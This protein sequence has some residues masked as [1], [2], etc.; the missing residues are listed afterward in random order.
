WDVRLRSTST[1]GNGLPS[2]AA[3][4]GSASTELVHLVFTRAADGEAQFYVDGK[5]QAA[6]RVAGDFSNWDDKQRLILANEHTG[7]R[8]WSGEFHRVAIYSAA[9]SEQQVAQH[10]AAGVPGKID[11]AA[12]LPP[13]ATRPIDFVKDVQPIFRA[14]CFECHAQGNEEGG[15]NLGMRARFTAGGDHGPVI[16]AGDGAASRLVHL[17]AGLVKDRR[18][19]PDDEG[20][21]LT[22]AQIGVLRAWID[23]G[24]KWPDGADVLDPRVERARQHWAFRP[25]SPVALPAVKNSAWV[26]TP[27]DQFVLAKLEAQGLSPAPPA[28][29]R[30]LMR[31]LAF[32]LAGL[33]PEP[34]AV[35]AFSSAADPSAAVAALADDLLASPRYGERWGRHWLDVARYADSDGQEA[36][37]DRPGAYH[38]RDFV[39]RALNDDLPFD[40][41]VRWQIAGDE[42]APGNPQAVAATGFLTAGPHT[43]L[44]NTF[45]EEERLRNRYNEL[46]DMVSTLGSA[47]LGVTLG[48]ARCHDHK[49]DAVSSREYYQLLAALHSGDRAEV[50]LPQGGGKALVFR[51]F[52][53]E[54][55]ATWLFERADF[56]DRDQPVQLGFPVALSRGKSAAEYKAAATPAQ[57]G[58][59]TYQRA[60]L[61]NWLTDVEQGAGALTARVIVNSVWQHHFAHGLSRTESDVGARGEEP[62]HPE[63]LDWLTI[64]FIEH[65]WKLKRLHRLIVTSNVYQQSGA[66][67]EAAARIDPE[68]RLLWRAAPRRQ[69]AEILR[70]AMLAVSGTLNLEPYGPAFKPAVAAEAMVARNIKGEAYPKDVADG[71]AVRRRT[72]YMFHKRVIPYPLLAAFDRPDS[73]Q[74]CGRR[75]ETTVA[76]QALALLNDDFVRRRA[77]DFADRLLKECGDDDAKLVRRSFALALGRAPDDA[78]LAA[79]SQFVAAQFTG[80]RARDGKLPADQARRLAVA[81]YCQ[82]LFGLNEFLY[83][84]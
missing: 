70:D 7:D 33:P 37:R 28:T 80:R 78:E 17:T 25:L 8:P 83:V 3:G 15:L 59:S 84:D 32:D 11:Y 60:A 43:V 49:Y 64:D 10:Y 58:P 31:R 18:M 56:Y 61:A 29:P 53:S 57:P 4:A 51:D 23:Q 65:G 2:T 62:T 39:I 44:E 38:Y 24:A 66:F 77:Y 73:L 74:S 22:A 40:T 6:G 20:E 41:F 81:D 19:P 27:I 71:P 82:S 30:Q 12:L 26:K 48:C 36:D 1:S 75:L 69:E 50:D 14:R 34:E 79:S 54:P 55:A 13:A 46:D 35:D 52:G 42:L 76:P 9:L 5:R 21:P 47:V 45:L 72:V 16:A 67:N 63:L 68:N